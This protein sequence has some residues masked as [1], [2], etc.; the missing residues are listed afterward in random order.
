[1][2]SECQQVRTCASG[3]RSA[4]RREHWWEGPN[5]SALGD[6]LQTFASEERGGMCV[7][8]LHLAVAPVRAGILIPPAV[9]HRNDHELMGLL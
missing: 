1:M 3:R 5:P 2:G 6:E 4:V 9:Q 7:W 8:W